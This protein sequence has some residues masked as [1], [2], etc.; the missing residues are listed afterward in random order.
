MVWFVIIIY[1]HF[2]VISFSVF[3]INYIYIYIYILPHISRKNLEF[4]HLLT[5]KTMSLSFSPTT[6][7]MLRGSSLLMLPIVV[8]TIRPPGTNSSARHLRNIV[9]SFSKCFKYASNTAGGLVFAMHIFP[10]FKA[11]WVSQTNCFGT[12]KI[13][14]YI[15]IYIYFSLLYI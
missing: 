1:K 8:R 4:R 12:Y 15:Y 14:R 9:K 5:S 11:S 6:S 13:Y 2:I 10:L 3:L 7:H